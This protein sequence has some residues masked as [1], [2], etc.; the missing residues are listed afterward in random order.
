MAGREKDLQEACLDYLERR[1]IYAVNTH[2]N[3]WERRGRPDLYICYRGRFIGCELKRGVGDTPTP[4]QRKHLRQIQ[5]N[6]GI[7]VWITTL[8]ELIC[9][10]NSLEDSAEIS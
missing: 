7:G 2:G 5:H 10:L 1:G 4:L 9:L 8:Q 6:G 3:A